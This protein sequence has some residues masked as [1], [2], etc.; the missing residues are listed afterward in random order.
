MKTVITIYK[1]IAAIIISI[2]LSIIIF[3]AFCL[4]LIDKKYLK[5][6]NEMLK[7]IWKFLENS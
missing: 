7:E 6:E 1:I 5:K 3:I 4:F 2:L